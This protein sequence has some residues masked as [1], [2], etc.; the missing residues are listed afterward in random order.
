MN[1]DDAG[2][3]PVREWAI[4]SAVAWIRDFHCDGLRLDA[5]HAVFDDSATHVLQEL[6]TRVHAADARA[7]VIAESGLNDPKVT[8]PP[9]RGYGHDA[10][11][12]TTSTTRCAACSPTSAR[13]TTRTSASS[14]SSRRR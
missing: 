5:I 14:G 13:A 7:L 4:R 8:R 2:S 10:A 11:W 3:D 6:A 9:P 1:F 12:A